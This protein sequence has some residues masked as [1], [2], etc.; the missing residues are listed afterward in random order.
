MKTLN[1]IKSFYHSYKR[2]T[3][4]FLPNLKEEASSFLVPGKYKYRAF[5][6]PM[7]V[8]IQSSEKA[9]NFIRKGRLNSSSIHGKK[10][11]IKSIIKELINYSYFKKI[12]IQSNEPLIFNGEIVLFKTTNVSIKILDFQRDEVLIYF[13]SKKHFNETEKNIS[14]LNN[15]INNAILSISNDKNYFIEKLITF[16]PIENLSTNQVRRVLKKYISDLSNYFKFTHVDDLRVVNTSDYIEYFMSIMTSLDGFDILKKELNTFKLI[17]NMPLV[18]FVNIKSDNSFN[19]FLIKGEDYYFID[20]EGRSYQSFL[21][22][23][24]T[25]QRSLSVRYNWDRFLI[26]YKNGYFDNS[27][28]SV[29]ENLNLKFNKELRDEYY[30]ISLL[31][32]YHFMEN[33]NLTHED[34]IKQDNSLAIKIFDNLKH[35]YNLK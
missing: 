23:L 34:L 20:F 1:I 4:Y 10:Y 14:S 13:L 27:I 29:F 28:N 11:M 3:K 6:V 12:K 24:I 35:Y 21:H 2:Y 26:D 15:E 31:N 8:R 25:F 16:D 22:L 5:P 7:L 9:K 30:F 33:K 32:Y 19:N 17:S 18:Y